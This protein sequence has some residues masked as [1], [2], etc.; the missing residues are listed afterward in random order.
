MGISEEH[1]DL[2]EAYLSGLL[3][4]REII[5]FEARLAYDNEFKEQF[6]NYQQIE[7]G[8]KQYYRDQMKSKFAE[9]DEQ[10]DAKSVG[11]IRYLKWWVISGAAAVAIIIIST[12]Y[13]NQ[14]NS[15][16]HENASLAAEY[17]PHEEGLPV[18]MSG[19]GRYDDAM[20]AFKQE[21]WE[22]A[23]GL[24]LK[25]DSDTASYFLGIVSYK[26]KDYEQALGYFKEVDAVSTYFEEVQFRL[27]LISIL[28]DDIDQ[29]K[30]FLEKL[31]DSETQYS[32]QAKEL[33]S[34]LE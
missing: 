27:A 24:L 30:V 23:E 32:E 20:N 22:K 14:F 17:W 16:I 3:T 7:G 4:E 33:L 11:K 19:K 9:V 21:Q 25:I 15:P 12:V 13:L 5:E 2:F 1:I 31:I 34:E 28:T 18:K 10:L 26:E 6:E 8:I 29:A